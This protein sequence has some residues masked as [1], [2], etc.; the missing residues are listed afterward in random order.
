MGEPET[1]KENE[2]E[3]PAKGRT[4]QYFIDVC[5]KFY[6]ITVE[7]SASFCVIVLIYILIRFFSV[8]DA[9]T[10]SFLMVAEPLTKVCEAASFSKPQPSESSSS[11]SAPSKNI[12]REQQSS[13]G[14]Q[15]N[16]RPSVPWPNVPRPEAYS[17]HKTDR[18]S[19]VQPD[20]VVQPDSTVPPLRSKRD[21]LP[22]VSVQEVDSVGFIC[23]ERKEPPANGIGRAK[24]QNIVPDARGTVLECWRR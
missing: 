8:E 21:S 12:I 1:V 16:V 24:E 18:D 13:Q 20:S 4:R 23:V 22:H 9:C 10:W 14:A 17:S 5:T 6:D 19:L 11:G 3:E 7:L 15:M 2:V